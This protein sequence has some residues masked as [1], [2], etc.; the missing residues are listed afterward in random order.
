MKRFLLSF[1]AVLATSAASAKEVPAIKSCDADLTFPG[2][3]RSEMVARIYQDGN[4]LRAQLTIKQDGEENTLTETVTV[5]SGAVRADLNPDQAANLTDAELFIA[6]AIAYTQEPELAALAKL[7]F[8]LKAVRSA[9]VY[10]IGE[11]T[12]MGAPAVIEAFDQDKKLLG[13]FFGGFYVAV[14][15]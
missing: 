8:D 3:P 15:R 6:H 10:Q 4:G 14:C 5:F 9:T 12:N 2:T 7:P 1:V 13:T 11:R